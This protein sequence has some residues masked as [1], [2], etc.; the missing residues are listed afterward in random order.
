MEKSA[1][2]WIQID[3]EGACGVEIHFLPTWQTPKTMRF[4]VR[5]GNTSIARPALDKSF[6]QVVSTD[7]PED[8]L[9]EGD[10][11]SRPPAGGQAV[12]MNIPTLAVD[13]ENN[14]PPV[15]QWLAADRRN[16]QSLAIDEGF[17]IVNRGGDG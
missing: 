12:V 15:L 14:G 17:H 4:E 6:L 8:V 10:F 9:L 3:Y 16:S 13:P 1:E 2:R 7:Q 5:A 11:R